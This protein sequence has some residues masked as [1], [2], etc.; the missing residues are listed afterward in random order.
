MKAIPNS[1]CVLTFHTTNY[2]LEFER[3]AKAEGIDVKLMPVPRQISTSCG[4]AARIP[5]DKEPEILAFCERERIEFDSVHE[6]KCE[7]K[8]SIFEKFFK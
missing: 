8:K 1:Y 3:K 4:T 2:A 7:E 5:C 6:I